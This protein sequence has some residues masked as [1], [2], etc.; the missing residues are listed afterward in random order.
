MRPFLFCYPAALVLALTFFTD[1]RDPVWK[2]ADETFFR[3]LNSTLTSEGIWPTLVAWSNTRIFDTSWGILMGLLCV[4]VF[5]SPR[6]GVFQDRFARITAAAF[7]VVA[8]IVV[9]KLAFRDFDRLSPG[10]YFDDFVNLNEIL[11]HITAKVG[12]SSSF[13]GDHGIASVML[14]LCFTIFFRAHPH[15][16]LIA[17]PIAIVNS[18]PRLIAGGHW[19]S[20]IMVGGGIAGFLV[21]PLLVG[22]PYLTLMQRLTSVITD[23][24][25]EPLLR[26]LGM[27]DKFR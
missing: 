14:V 27:S 7:G 8:T 4:W 26:K 22:T 19:L 3:L 18:L 5:I 9:A 1:Y 2:T 20:D 12:S 13:P 24:F 23:R 16:S 11:P 6:Y 10:R 21:Y 17:L 25:I 15:L